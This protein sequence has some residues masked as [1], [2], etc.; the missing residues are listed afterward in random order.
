M[1]LYTIG[2]NK[3]P[4]AEFFTKLTASG[5][6]RLV[7]VRI[8][9]TSQ[10]SGYTKRDDIRY[11]ARAIC[12]INYQH[13]LELAPTKEMFH[14]YKKAGGSWSIYQRRFAD[15]IA[16][17]R[18][19]CIDRDAM[20]GACLLCSERKPHHCHRRLVAEYLYQRWASIEIIHL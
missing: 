7:D 6:L 20:D 12:G 14:D 9:N 5:A 15:L 19:E 3:T 10:L 16:A 2:Y 13:R 8:S 18:I 17:R 11:F 1:R 4:A